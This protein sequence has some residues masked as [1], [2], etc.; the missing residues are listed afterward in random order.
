MCPKVRVSF[1]KM[2]SYK[3]FPS[4]AG[5]LLH[6]TVVM[7]DVSSRWIQLYFFCNLEGSRIKLIHLVLSPGKRYL[8][9]SAEG[10]TCFSGRHHTS[11]P[12][13]R[14]KQGVAR[15][16]EVWRLPA[17]LVT[18]WHCL[19]VLCPFCTEYFLLPNLS[20]AG[21]QVALAAFHVRSP[22]RAGC[23]HVLPFMSD[24]KR[25]KHSST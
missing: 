23:T 6:H 20:E 5:C 7:R 12:M 13:P 19:S 1:I 18:V 15:Y 9:S 14:A 22:S 17:K 8:A 2:I 10:K 4:T 24:F 25:N 3:Y 16:E 21:P 11:P